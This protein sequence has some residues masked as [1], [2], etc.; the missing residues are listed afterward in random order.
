MLFLFSNPP[1][2]L[3]L[4]KVDQEEAF[5]QRLASSAARRRQRKHP[6][7]RRAE[8]APGE[9]SSGSP[10]SDGEW[11]PGAGE[12]EADSA[13]PGKPPEEPA[14]AEKDGPTPNNASPVSKFEIPSPDFGF[15]ADEH[16]EV[17]VS[18]SEN[19]SHFWIQILGSRCLQ[20]DNLT[21][22][23]SRYYSGLS[24]T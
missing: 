3:I 2:A 8:R 18:A 24:G 15:P 19:P 20:L 5:R 21:R 23:M 11:A 6:I 4:A 17:Y 12:S 14:A 16:L 1:S 10:A 9:E 13:F 7:G 22:E